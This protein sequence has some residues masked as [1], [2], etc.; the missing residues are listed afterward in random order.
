MPAKKWNKERVIAAIRPWTRQRVVEAIRSRHEQGLSLSSVWRED[1]SL[2]YIATK[3]F[4]TWR[5]A[6]EAAGFPL[7]PAR[8]WTPEG[9]IRAIQSRCERGL[10]LVGIDREDRALYAA[11]RRHCGG[12]RAA[13]QAAGIET[14]PHRSWSR[15]SVVDALV[16]WQARGL[17]LSRVWTEDRPLYAAAARNFGNWNNTLQALGLPPRQK[18][19]WSKQRVVLKLQAWYRQGDERPRCVGRALT[20]AAI[21][22]FGSLEGAM[23]VAGVEPKRRGWTDRRVIDAIQGRYVRGQPIDVAGFGNKALAAAAQRRF[24]GWAEALAAAGLSRKYCKPP[25]KRTWTKELV[26]EAILTRRRQGLPLRNISRTDSGLYQAAGKYLG[27][28]PR[29]L[30]TAGIVR[31]E[32]AQ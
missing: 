6:M 30:A 16:D 14:K 21:R 31:D 10:P 9:V 7:P 22:L 24:G 17:S 29:A 25:P 20:D 18:G 1:K 3:M 15:Q 2:R 32:E 5:L 27:S 12:W 26:I 11:A 23:E 28:W 8:R 19:P 4:G 13:L